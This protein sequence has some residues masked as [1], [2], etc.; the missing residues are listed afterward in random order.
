MNRRNFLTGMVGILAY[1]V[2]PAAIRSDVLMPVR[3][4]ITP[5]EFT[6]TWVLEQQQKLRDFYLGDQW[7]TEEIDGMRSI[8]ATPLVFNLIKPLVHRFDSS[9]IGP[10]HI[11]AQRA[12]NLFLS[13][14]MET[15]K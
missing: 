15:P 3:K 2:A 8:G 14:T 10:E 9:C 13:R 1:G 12:L 6:G 7:T 4:I 5:M 11:K